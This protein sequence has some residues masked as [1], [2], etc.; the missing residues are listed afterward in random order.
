MTYTPC[1]STQCRVTVTNESDQCLTCT[2]PFSRHARFLQ[3]GETLSSKITF[4][5]ESNNT[6]LE[7][8]VVT[9]NLDNNIANANNDLAAN[10]ITFQ[11]NGNYVAVTHPPTMNPTTIAPTSSEPTTMSPSLS[12]ISAPSKSPNVLT[13]T[14]KPSEV[15]YNITQTLS[16]DVEFEL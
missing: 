10:N 4:K 12:P 7:E 1:N 11:V 8:A 9:S 3:I 15:K 2:V 6:L 14:E 5:I 16:I 13:I